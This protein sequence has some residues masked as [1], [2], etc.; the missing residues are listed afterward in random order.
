MFQR[1]AR[2]SSEAESSF[3]LVFLGIE[4]VAQPDVDWTRQQ[5]WCKVRFQQTLDLTPEGLDREVE[6]L[7][8]D[9][10]LSRIGSTPGEARDRSSHAEGDGMTFKCYT[11]LEVVDGQHLFCAD[12][13]VKMLDDTA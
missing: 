5:M 3:F 10:I 8:W 4:E 6:T 13:H 7:D 2:D 1:T 9:L 12:L 11:Q